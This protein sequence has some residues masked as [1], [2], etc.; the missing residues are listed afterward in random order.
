[1]PVPTVWQRSGSLQFEPLPACHCSTPSTRQTPPLSNFTYQ[2]HL[3]GLRGISIL[4]VAISHAGMG[5]LVPGGLGVT[6]FFFISGYL[7]TSLLLSEREHTGRIDLPSFY[8]RRFWRL[9][10]PVV[11]HVT[12]A[13]VL[14]FLVNGAV[15]WAEPASILLYFSNYYKL[16][17]HYT[18]VNGEYS[19][20]DI[21]WSLAVEEH[22][23]LVFTP[24]L[25]VLRSK[26]SLLVLVAVLLLVPVG[27]RMWVTANYGEIFSSEY[28]YRATDARM[29][30]IAYGCLLALLGGAAFN[31]RRGVVLFCLGVLA[32]LA[33]LLVRDEYFRQVF[34]YSLQGVGIY[35]ICG[36][37][38][39]SEQL[40]AVRKLLSNAVLVYV[41]KLSYSM[42][43]YHWF[44]LVI[45][46]LAVGH[47][48]FTL[49]WQG[50]YWV[51]TLG[52]SVASY[53][54]VEKPSVKLRRRFGSN[55][56]A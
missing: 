17:P 24:L 21:Y 50:L 31:G 47:S 39:F 46:Y 9:T 32:M 2:P 7:I 18:M 44:A 23:Y 36:G 55:A 12:L 13:L 38:I 28:T 1:M 3:D 45:V 5:K 29:D 22:F 52:A 30:S 26:R 43:L 16:F 41:G 6:V 27:I 56:Q 34:R 42:Y 49:E 25:M 4:L 37:V 51:L 48:Y 35:L 19:P 15:R 8:L 40:G 33:S 20:F 54:G 11:V 53:H 10:P 14:I